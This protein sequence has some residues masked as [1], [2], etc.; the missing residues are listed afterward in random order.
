MEVL[1]RAATA[2][3][4][5]TG[6]VMKVAR[7]DGSSAAGKIALSV[8]YKAFAG[9]YGA[10][11]ASRLRLVS[12]PACALTT[13]EERACA[14]TPLKSTN[15]VKAKA[16]SASVAVSS[17]GSV[18]ALAAAPSGPSGSYAAT[19][20]QSS[21]TWSA[22]GNSGA[23]NWSYPMRVPPS[24]GGL[25]PQVSVGYNS[26]SVD[27]R[28]A[29]SNNQPSWAGEGFDVGAGGLI[30]R[31]YLPCAEDMDDDANNDE[32]T[33]DMC[34][35]TNNAVLSL[36]GHSGELIYN[37][38]EGRWHLRADDGTRIRRETGGVNGDN[39]G[40]YWVVTTTDG[41]QYWFGL[42]RLPGWTSGDPVTESTYTVPVYGNDPNEPC[43]AT[44]FEDSDCVQAWR[45]NLD[46]VVDVNGN[47][48]SYWYVKETNK[49][50][51]NLDSSDAPTYVRGGYLDRVDYGT[52][53]DNNIESVLDAPA[54]QRVD[55]GVA[56][57]CVSNCTTK[58]ATNWP[59]VPWD[60]ECTGTPCENYSPTFWTTKRLATVTTQ[61]RSGS[62][63]SNVERWT[64][65]HSF[66][67]P[68]DGT[69]AGLWLSKLSHEGLAGTT[70]TV[71]DIE[72][73]G[74]QLANRVD[75]VDFAPAMNWWRVARIRNESGGTIN[76]TYSAPECV[77]GSP[78]NP[79]T[80]TKRCY[81]VRWTPEGAA[82]P[83]QDWFHKYVVTDIYEID[84]TGG[85]APQGSPRIAYHYTYYDG[86]AWHYTD[87]DGLVD[88]K[89]RDWSDYRGYGRVGVTVGD[90]DDPG[91][92]YTETKFFRGMHGDR[93]NDSG[94]T[95]TVTI[96]GTGVATVNDENAYA[97]LARETTVFNG[98]GGAVV[99]REV[100]E[101]W[102]S[103]ATATRG[104]VS[105]RFVA[106]KA[107]HKRAARDGGRADLVAS[108]TTTFDAYG[109]AVQVEDL[110]DTAVTG[111]E[112][113]VKT[114]Y[115]PRNNTAWIMD[116]SHKVQKYAV[117]CASTTGTLTEAQI[118][119]EDRTIYDDNAF[120]EA[121][122]KG[123]V[124]KTEVM[125]TWNSGSPTFLTTSRFAY[126]IHGRATSTWDALN[127]ESKTE[128]TPLT[129]GPVTAMKATNP[130]GHVTTTT[131][132]PAYG[133]GTAIVDANL[134][135]T[136]IAYDGLGRMTSV[137]LPGRDKATKTANLTF[138]YQL[139]TNAPTVVST[140]SLNGSEQYITRYA[141]YDGLMRDRQ[142]QTASP[143]G[144]RL[145]TENFYDTVG[146]KVKTYNLYYATGAPSATLVTATQRTDVP[147]QYRTV[148]DGAKRETA[149]IFQP[150]D[151]ERW[152]TTTAYGG[153]R[154]DVTPPAGGTA[155]STVVDAH[156]RTTA[157]RQYF[158][159]TPTPTTAGTWD[160]TSYA[161]NAKGQLATVTD[162]LG[163]E[164]KSTYDLLGRLSEAK[165]PDKGTTKYGYDNAGRL[166]SVTDSN[167]KKLLFVLDALGRKKSVY[168]DS[169]SGTL[170][171][172]W[173]YDTIAKGQLSTSTRKVGTALYQSKILAY[174]DRYQPTQSEIV[175]PSAETGLAGTYAYANTYNGVD[176]SL[177]S[178]TLPGMA[179]GGLPTETLSYTHNSLGMPIAMSS[180]YGT[181]PGTN[182]KLV[183]AVAYNALGQ[184]EQIT[185]DTDDTAGGRVWQSY[186]R[187]LETGRITGIRT[188][189]DTVAPY[190]VMDQRLTYDNAGNITK[191]TDAAPDPVD[192]T[193]CFT[194][195]FLRRLTEAWTPA[196]GDCNAAK[197]TAALG[198]PAP[199]WHTWALDKTGN[200]TKLTVHTTSMNYVTDYQYP[201]AGAS[202]TRP[203]AVNS[204]TGAQVSEY[205]YDANGATLC[206][207]AG[208]GTNDCDASNPTTAG[209][210]VLTWDPEGHLATSTDA[211]GATSYI[212]DADGNRLIR[213][214][215]TGKTLYLPGQEVRYTTSSQVVTCT[216]YYALGDAVFASRDAAG[217]TWLGGDHQGT[218][219]VSIRQSDQQLTARR[220][221]PYGGARGAAVT[222]P[223]TKG[224]VGGTTDNTGLT[225]LGAREYDPNTGR[226]ISVD[227]VMD[228]ND[229]QQWNGYSYSGNSPITFSDPSGLW[230]FAS[231][232]TASCNYTNQYAASACAS[233]TKGY[234]S[235]TITVAEEFSIFA[236]EY[237]NCDFKK[238]IL[239]DFPYEPY[240]KN[241]VQQF[242]CKQMS[243]IT[244]TE[245]AERNGEVDPW[246]MLKDFTGVSD[247]EDCFGE[248]SVSG[249]V[250][251]AVNVIGLIFTIAK[252]GKIAAMARI[253]NG[254]KAVGAA[255]EASKVRFTQTVECLLG[256]LKK[257]SFSGDTEVLMADGTRKRIS[258]I[259]VG[260]EVLATD[261][262]TG[263]QAP[264]KVTKVWVHDDMLVDLRLDGG[265]TVTTTEDHL[266]WNA[267]DRQWQE[268]QQFDE[269]D[270]LYTAGG[271]SVAVAGLNMATAHRA[272]AYNLTVAGIHTYYVFALST[273]VLVHNEACSV[274]MVGMDYKHTFNTSVGEIDFFA[275]EVRASDGTL[276]LKD[277][278]IAPGRGS[279]GDWEA[280]RKR[281]QR[282]EA[283]D[284]LKQ[285]EDQARLQGYD[286]LRITG[287]RTTGPA[288][289][290]VTDITRDLT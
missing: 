184:T 145:I 63:Y 46:Y 83:K 245:Y 116:K 225:H 262:E 80:N 21:S 43:H 234:V 29:A 138:G 61:V 154:T 113:C 94:G 288:A 220:Q 67:D 75:T 279:I 156:G 179:T 131:L 68:G 229:P 147:N 251:T 36:A 228:M 86:V 95:R 178:S 258:E 9:A 257:D 59:D 27:G 250:W 133:M 5:V 176:G 162:A 111:D 121:P 42:N 280:L 39:D 135:R 196:S 198:G 146:N 97:G 108:A 99:T 264:R 137:W 243:G 177:T 109:M 206:R 214:D 247:A 98:P 189:R 10:D 242:L 218:A 7:T 22:G 238:D 276:W 52:R 112:T 77:A 259:R 287:V 100:N 193:Q 136:D 212:Y 167:N 270:L 172:Q 12:L 205:R 207:P 87:D 96:T 149:V 72:F 132:D 48:M 192:D 282:G 142:T 158:G 221:L 213:R 286:K 169:L 272:R 85:A 30:E 226:F 208:T 104:S 150:Y 2:K 271:G 256:A 180:L 201:A 14:G 224:F 81:P 20:L 62:S 261:P 125:S 127:Y 70:T 88:P 239:E 23:F 40:E 289:G 268:T 141:L 153:D 84:H 281:L 173:V 6:V 126:D 255:D 222:W 123:L 263:E 144:G 253:K 92:T 33:G 128:F 217:L 266:F 19:S 170:R 44:A 284:F 91:R 101:P 185:L 151:A 260:D 188:D 106:I 231:L 13:P 90:P 129:G 252:V 57:R 164:W 24:A 165:D 283:M 120:L 203:H 35:E 273:P 204:T 143:S 216:R 175:I 53:R 103:A 56:D 191:I 232:A 210:Q 285:L 31:R 1:D 254:A 235:V 187:Q 124:A 26:Q 38:T 25:A 4:G 223:N 71:P 134:K 200:R 41:T 182:L 66:P 32:K 118:I 11:W 211:T 114:T 249:C 93:A 171:A 275:N 197:S 65:R 265:A 186:T 236:N 130:L 47:S 157:L 202:A 215:P 267:T 278:S 89:D 34:W 119:G 194:Y 148:F 60:S 115:E 78:P 17:A 107:T 15:D 45:W 122:D 82:T 49:Y 237:C 277:V 76:I 152:R 183:P 244:C 160:Q 73:A 37:S 139:R 159:A 199:Y 51:R 230:S 55:F 240:M 102:Q 110:G 28:H 8:D 64:L 195:D 246:K 168:E 290:H 105:A 174:N 16:V 79:A 166:T 274:F 209:S 50:G 74:I 219:Q 241:V 269:G 54:P 18:V 58:N 233:A 227:P 161:Y 140:S 69:R 155:A 117:G 3:A 190:T 248:G 181:S 163:N